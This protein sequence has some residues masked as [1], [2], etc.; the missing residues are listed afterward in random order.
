MRIQIDMDTLWEFKLTQISYPYNSLRN[1][2]LNALKKYRYIN[3]DTPFF[4][5]QDP[6]ISEP[7]TW[8]IN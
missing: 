3:S 6:L 7:N 5:C 1:S 4:V 2:R 8:N